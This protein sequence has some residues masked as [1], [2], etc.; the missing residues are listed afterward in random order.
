MTPEALRIA[1]VPGVVITRWSRLWQQRQPSTAL[2][3]TPVAQQ[4]QL[5][6]LLEERAELAFVRLPVDDPA[7][8]VI[9]LW[10]EETVAVVSV[11]HPLAGR[12]A[13]TLAELEGQHVDQEDAE[14]AVQIVAA[15]SGAM[16]VPKGVAR[17]LARKD[18]E[19]IPVEDAAP[20]RIAL[21][22]VTARHTQ[23]FEDFIGIVRGRTENSSRG[24]QTR[25]QGGAAARDQPREGRRRPAIPQQ[26]R[27][28]SRRR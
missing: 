4:D 22:W 6:T 17:Q 14:M 25:Q 18:V 13:L 16:V 28:R 23:A 26:Q 8:S 5:E 19:V 24:S 21:A 3:V 1:I 9:P 7:L 2:E 15:G 12:E 20:T 27:R 10:T 11:D